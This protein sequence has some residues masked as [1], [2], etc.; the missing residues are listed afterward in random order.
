M[1]L[2]L[3]ILGVL[4]FA[5]FNVFGK[6]R[7]HKCLMVLFA[8]LFIISGTL[9]VLNDRN[10]FGMRQIV[11][12]KQINLVSSSGQKELPV[13]LY[14]PLGDS[15]EKIYLYQTNDKKEL[16]KTGTDQ[17][18]NKLN[19]TAKEAVLTQETH[20]WEYKSGVYN[21]LFGISGNDHKYASQ[22]NTFALP[23]TWQVLSVTEAKA[24][25]TY[26]KEHQKELATSS[27]SYVQEKLKTL[28]ATSPTL[29]EKEQQ[30]AVQKFT[31]EFQQKT[32]SE[33]LTQIN[34]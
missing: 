18:T 10:D 31:A 29:S 25:A 13:L 24:L 33:V 19:T 27:V 22:T 12:K 9:I 23:K 6:T 21:L 8:L 3:L 17:V 2:L 26:M 7:L 14:Q 11:E 34:K 15:T 30:E 5:G 20:Y 28:L 32:I 4:G 16:Q 1:I